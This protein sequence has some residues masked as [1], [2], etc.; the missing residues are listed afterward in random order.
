L[1]SLYSHASD[2]EGIELGQLEE[3]EV[4]EDLGHKSDPT[5]PAPEGYQKISYHVVYAVKHDRRRKSRLVAGGHLTEVPTKSVYSSVVSLRGVRI[6]IFLV[7][8]NGLKI[9]QTD[10]GNAYLEAK[11]NK[12]VYVIAGPEF[13]QKERTCIHYQEGSIWFKII[14]SWHERFADILRNMKFF[15]CKADQRYG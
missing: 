1:A 12:K 11:T 4:F 15:P 6:V 5:A 3:Y 8:L 10:I 2:S 7:E 14:R 13:G 9:W